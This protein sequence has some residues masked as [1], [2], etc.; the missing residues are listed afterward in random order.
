[1]IH[2]FTLASGM[3]HQQIIGVSNLEDF[4]KKS[5]LEI[6]NANYFYKN[7]LY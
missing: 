1:M 3:I 4:K 5:F 2:Y 6:I 7:S